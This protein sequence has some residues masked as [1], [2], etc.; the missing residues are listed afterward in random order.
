M[1]R[2]IVIIGASGA[3]GGAMVEALSQ[4]GA[5]TL[6]AFSRSAKEFPQDNVISGHLDFD[7]EDTI[8]KAA[9]IASEGG[10]I[11][12][13]VVATGVL[14]EGGIS[15]EKSIKTL[16]QDNMHTLFQVN[17]VGPAMVMKY[18]L[19]VMPK[20]T[21]YIIASL[22]ARVGSIS[23]NAL[24]GWYSYR[25]AKAALNMVIKTASIEATRRNDLSVIMG[26]HPGTVDS[27]LSKP[28]QS[29]VPEGKLFDA[30]FSAQ[31]LLEV[32]AR[33]SADDTGKL[34]AWDGQEIEY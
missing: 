20:N 10:A 7:D 14:H 31:K 2:N 16:S 6:Y 34:F 33:R 3:I 28:F 29:F 19:P 13:V 12:M 18:F 30:E 24:G 5:N 32:M 1:S 25:A 4:D 17:T 8:E 23:D 27:D 22:S 9:A 11:D 21:P 15:P 26:L